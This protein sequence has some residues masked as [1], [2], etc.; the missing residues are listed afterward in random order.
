M[1]YNYSDQQEKAISLLE[2]FIIPKHSDIE[3]LLDIYL[4]L[5]MFYIQ[6][7]DLKKAKFIFSKF[8]H[9]D[10]YYTEKAGKEWVLKKNLID[11]ILNI[12]LGNINLVESRLLSFKR[13]NYGYLRQINQQRAITYLGFV[14]SYYKNPEQVTSKDFKNKVEQS[15]E[16]IGPDRED[17]FVMSF[18]AWLKSKMEKYSLYKTT[19]DLVSLAQDVNS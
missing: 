3:S 2:S 16:W 19:L 11:I 9:T 6:K 18:Y 13:N 15:F 14:E 12:E 17:I 4:S 7:P 5:V 1:N 8:Y 10:K